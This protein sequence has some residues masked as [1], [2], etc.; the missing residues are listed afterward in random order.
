[1][2]PV[3]GAWHGACQL[4]EQAHHGVTYTSSRWREV[5]RAVLIWEDRRQGSRKKVTGGP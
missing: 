2:L 1:M 3:R 4:W 5:N